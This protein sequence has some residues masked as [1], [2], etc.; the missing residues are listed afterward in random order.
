MNAETQKDHSDVI[1]QDTLQ[2]LQQQQLQLEQLQQ[3]R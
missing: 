2:P 3:H 1:D